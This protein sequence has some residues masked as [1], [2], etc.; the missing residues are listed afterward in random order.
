MTG[1]PL[2]VAVTARC[3]SGGKPFSPEI[4]ARAYREVFNYFEDAIYHRFD[5]PV[6]RFFAGTC[7]FC[8]LRLG[9]G[10]NITERMLTL[11]PR[12]SEIQQKGTPDI[13][14]AVNGLLPCC[15]FWKNLM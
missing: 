10:E 12:M 4:V 2:G 6:Q 1:Y 14:F 5:L 3:M 7:S 9:N 11:I 8:A 15:P 13:E